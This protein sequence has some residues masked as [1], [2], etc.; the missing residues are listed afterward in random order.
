MDSL[1]SSIKNRLVNGIEVTGTGLK[2]IAVV[3]MFLDHIA[4][5]PLTNW[6]LKNKPSMS[7]DT[8]SFYYS[9]YHVLRAIGRMA[10]PIYCFLLVEGVAHTRNIRKYA[11]RVLTVA[12]LAE[13]P[14]DYLFYHRLFYWQHN[15][16]LWGLLLGLICLHLYSLVEKYECSFAL[17]MVIMCAGMAVAHFTFLD[18]GEAGICCI[19]LMSIL[20]GEEP[21]I[22]V[23]AFMAG[24]GALAIL[25]STIELF[26][27]A[28]V[29]P[30]GMYRGGRGRDSKFIRKF[31]YLFYP[32]HICLL[33]LVDYYIVQT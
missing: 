32:L 21:G 8:Y 20:N 2:I 7:A 26:A 10:F 17:K 13:V 25:S 28:M 30:I 14:F 29:V 15:N 18:Y 4:L 27:M 33:I 19:C 23:I 12:L 16:V 31:F 11:L 6:I 22:R 5:G 1:L 3:T 24:V 9:F